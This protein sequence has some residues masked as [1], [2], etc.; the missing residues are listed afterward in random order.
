M[1]SRNL[2]ALGFFPG[3][4]LVALLQPVPP[5]TLALPRTAFVQFLGRLYLGYSHSSW[6]RRPSRVFLLSG[7]WVEI[8][9]VPQFQAHLSGLLRW[10][11]CPRARTA[12][13]SL[14]TGA[15][16]K[17]LSAG[18]GSDSLPIGGHIQDPTAG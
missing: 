18:G 8:S 17:T 15:I 1:T 6:C 9:T 5:I 13:G 7:R 12:G 16:L 14:H 3:C 11:R 10:S 2:D 4:A